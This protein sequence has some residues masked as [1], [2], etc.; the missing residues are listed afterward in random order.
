MLTAAS[1]LSDDDYAR[2]LQFRTGLRRF[3]RWSEEQAVAVGVTPAQ[4]QLML[5]IRGHHDRRGPTIGDLA[6]ALLLRHHST[7]ELVD[8]AV[9]A[10]LIERRGDRD[11]Q[12]VVRLALTPRGA[13]RLRRLSARH[14]EELRRF[15]P[16]L[17]RVWEGLGP[18]TAPD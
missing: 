1:T 12:R 3:F 2:L 5:A 15:A 11:D 18:P 10:G 17:R 6:E 13:R 8:R 7:V 16:T 14:L 4:H 9:A